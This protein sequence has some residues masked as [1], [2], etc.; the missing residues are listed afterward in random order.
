MSVMTEAVA[1]QRV[2]IEAVD[3]VRGVIMI[4][5]AL[6]HTRDF[7]GNSGVNPP[8]RPRPRSR[9]FSHAG[10]RIS[11]RPF[12][13]YSPAPALALS[14]HK[15]S[16]SELSR[17][18]FTRGL[19]LIFLGV[20]V[21]RC[22]GWQFNFDY[23]ILLPNVLCHLAAVPLCEQKRRT[24]LTS[25]CGNIQIRFFLYI[26]RGKVHTKS[27]SAWWTDKLHLLSKSKRS[28]PF[29]NLTEGVLLP[30]FHGT[31]AEDLGI[32]DEAPDTG[33]PIPS[34]VSN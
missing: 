14:L 4:L 2:R 3:V 12:S 33:R 20:A 32:R 18:L 10:L 24:C 27:I 11:V 22:F 9:Y 8:I 1:S 26:S 34:A 23:H 13:F 19:G 30:L 15:K 6:D 16:K 28:K 5:M 29:V 17:F 25:R 21:V 7:F 31:I